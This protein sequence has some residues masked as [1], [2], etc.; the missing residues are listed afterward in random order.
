[1]TTPVEP[2]TDG[3]VYFNDPESGAE[4]ARLI[5][6]DRLITQGMGG[7]LPEQSNDFAD[8]HRILDIGCGPGGWLLDIAFEHPEIEAVGI[9]ISR[10]MTDYA[11][12]RAKV[13]GLH[14]ATFHA[15]DMLQPLQFPDHFFDLVNGRFIAFLPI[16]AWPSFLQECLRVTRPGGSIRLTESEWW[17]FSTSLALEQQL[18]MIIHALKKGGQSFSPSGNLVGITPMLRSLLRDAGCVNIQHKAHTIDYSF[19]EEVHQ[20]F[21]KDFALS[22]RFMQPF[23]FNSGV[24]TQEELDQI[25]QQLELDM[26]Q[27]DF[28]AIM[29]I[30]T[31]WGQKPQ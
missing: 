17:N 10:A 2:P 24:A 1:M 30:L 12:G 19:G 29:F 27:E 14:N 31:A 15:M 25:Q 8:M 7:P 23:I 18:G 5:D 22:S 6:Q 16:K 28:R 3:N 11:R 26:M 4:M 20:A 13:Q 9:D 21:C